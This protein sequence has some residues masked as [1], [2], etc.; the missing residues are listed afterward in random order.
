MA[1]PEFGAVHAMRDREDF[2]IARQAMRDI[3]QA[4]FLVRTVPLGFRAF[5]WGSARASAPTRKTCGSSRP[6]A[7]VEG[8]GE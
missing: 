1:L 8:D 5:V 2:D 6:L 7:A 3:E 4:A